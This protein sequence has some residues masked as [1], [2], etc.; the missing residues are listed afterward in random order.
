MF[1]IFLAIDK[2]VNLFCRGFFL[3]FL[4]IINR[5]LDVRTDSVNLSHSA[6]EFIVKDQEDKRDQK[7][8]NFV[9]EHKQELLDKFKATPLSFF[10]HLNRI[11]YYLVCHIEMVLQGLWKIFIFL[12]L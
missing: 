3:M 12:D 1:L 2:F 7:H 4:V 8:V 9:L 10:D 6:S 5:N 11:L